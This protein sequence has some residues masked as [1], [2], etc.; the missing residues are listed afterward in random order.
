MNAYLSSDTEDLLS[1]LPI[2]A[3]RLDDVRAQRLEFERDLAATE[4][5]LDEFVGLVN[6]TN[7]RLAQKHA[8]P[9]APPPAPVVPAAPVSHIVVPEIMSTAAVPA[10]IIPPAPAAPAAP[11]MTLED[12]KLHM[13]EILKGS[14][15][16]VSDKLSTRISGMLKELGTLSGPARE[17]RIQQFQQSGEY[18]MVDFSSLYSSSQAKVTSNLTEV[19]VEEKETKSVN[20]TLDR[21]RKLRAGKGK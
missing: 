18:D 16:A 7:L 21:L 4:A 2:L 6:I 12:F 19:G 9:K 17:V 10:S 3:R 5:S 20:S 14:L 8:E 11:G 15:D 13:G 1:A